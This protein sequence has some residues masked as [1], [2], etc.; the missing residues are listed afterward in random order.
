MRRS[1]GRPCADGSL[2]FE[3][4]I[5]SDAAR[6]VRSLAVCLTELYGTKVLN[7]D[8]VHLGRTVALRAGRATVRFRIRAVHL[9]PGFCRVGLWLADP[10]KAPHVSGAYDFVEPVAPAAS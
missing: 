2:E 6:D 10:V 4:E 7:A 5:E 3:L 9:M 8:T 1:G